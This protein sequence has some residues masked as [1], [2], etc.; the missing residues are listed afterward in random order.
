MI[1]SNLTEHFRVIP[2][3]DSHHK[4]KKTSYVNIRVTSRTDR[5]KTYDIPVYFENGIR[6][7]VIPASFKEGRVSKGYYD[8]SE[9]LFINDRIFNVWSKVK[10]FL[11]NKSSI[12]KEDVEVYV[13]GRAFLQQHKKARTKQ[14]SVVQIQ[15]VPSQYFVELRKQYPKRIEAKIISTINEDGFEVDTREEIIVDPLS[16]DDPEFP[17]NFPKELYQQLKKEFLN[18]RKEDSVKPWLIDQYI[19]FYCQ[20]AF[21]TIKGKENVVIQPTVLTDFEKTFK[22]KFDADSPKPQVKIN[23]VIVDKGD[24]Q[25]VLALKQNFELNNH[26]TER[27]FE[28]KKF[29][30]NNLL[31]VFG[32]VYF[33]TLKNQQNE[34]VI[35]RIFDYVINTNASINTKNFTVKWA[36]DFISWI[37]EHGY[38]D[39][40][41]KMFDPLKFDKHIFLNKDRK[42]YRAAGVKKQL[43]SFKVVGK[44]LASKG[45]LP[46]I[47]WD[48]IKIN[49]FRESVE[50]GV[51]NTHHLL[52]PEFETMFNY[53]FKE[54]KLKEY[55]SLFDQLKK[56]GIIKGTFVNDIS[57][58][59]LK[60]YRDIFAFQ[61]MIG[62][63]RGIPEYESVEL[64]DY[65]KEGKV[66][67]FMQDKVQK[68]KENKKHILNPLN[69]YTEELLK[70]HKTLPRAKSAEVLNGYL[71]VIAYTIGLTREV[72]KGVS[73]CNNISQYWARK[74]FGNILFS[75]GLS[76]DQI[77][78]FTGHETR[79]SE[80]G[81]SYLDL[82]NVKLKRKILKSVSFL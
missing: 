54:S 18:G 78:L 26:P 33:D 57:I 64:I 1:T 75:E 50:E 34:R 23:N 44:H 42:P 31:H 19:K 56:Q 81:K 49:Q 15:K 82:Q 68:G 24:V 45:L 63:L 48:E 52:L 73:I 35:I 74:S 62:G 47:D 8:E 72:E 36:T 17:K 46:R 6:M 40:S 76:E 60:M 77:A 39:L 61:I 41:A 21:F 38:I 3:I 25:N 30:K 53:Q 16:L 71:K 7:K 66:F 27:I 10:L 5:N 67:R 12:F 20:T 2:I 80:L 14:V 37:N 65:D 69:K 58:E 4:D 9:M 79:K 55:R 59:N 22:R 51:R 70:R 11:Q 32:S 43:V 28:Q 13:Y 29:D